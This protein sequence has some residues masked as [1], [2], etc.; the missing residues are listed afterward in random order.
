MPGANLRV[1]AANLRVILANLRVA[2]ANL[3]VAAAIYGCN[4][5]CAL[6][7]SLIVAP[8]HCCLVALVHTGVDLRVA[9]CWLA[10]WAA[11][12]AGVLHTSR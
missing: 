3:R 10:E 6:A 7:V 11:E 9:G 2:A 12:H 8:A 1:A 5:G 4:G